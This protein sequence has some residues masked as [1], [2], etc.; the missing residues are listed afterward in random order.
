MRI[1]SRRRRC[2][3]GW[4]STTTGGGNARA[5]ACV[6]PLSCLFSFCLPSFVRISSFCAWLRSSH[7]YDR[8]HPAHPSPSPPI[9]YVF[10]PLLLLPRASCPPCYRTAP[11]PLAVYATHSTPLR[12]PLR[13]SSPLPSPSLSRPRTLCPPRPHDPPSTPISM[14][15]THAVCYDPPLTTWLW[16]FGGAARPSV[17][18][19]SYC[20]LL[21]VARSV[22]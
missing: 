8:L 13:P 12:M 16:T 2:W 3:D 21:V 5:R 14:Y 20:F 6:P 15:L 9:A 17:S 11:P 4:S 10:F 7:S 22:A 19:S 1:A 18:S